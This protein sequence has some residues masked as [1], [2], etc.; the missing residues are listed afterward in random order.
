MKRIKKIAIILIAFCLCMIIFPLNSHADLTAEQRQKV[1]NFAK[2]FVIKGN[3]KDL[4]RYSQD[5]RWYGYRNQLS[6]HSSSNNLNSSF[7]NKLAFD[8]SSFAAFVYDQTCDAGLGALTTSTFDSSLEFRHVGTYNGNTN[9]LLVGDLL[10]KSYDHIVIYI[11]NG[12]IAHASEPNVQTQVKI[13]DL[14]SYYNGYTILRYKGSPE[15][16]KGF[17]SY[18]WPDGTTSQWTDEQIEDFE[19]VG[20][21]NGVFGS[22]DLIESGWIL[23]KLSELLDWF[24]GMTTYIVRMVFVGWTSIIE[25]MING[26]MELTSGEEASLTIE[27]LVNNKVPIFDVNFFNFE[28]AGGVKLEEGSVI[29]VIRENIAVWYYIIRSIAIV[30]LLITLLYLGIRMALAT[31]GE[32]KAK[33]KE[34]LVSW[35]VSFFIV[36][37]I[38]YIMILILNINSGLIDVINTSLARWRRVII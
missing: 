37:F 29:Y 25:M 2:A 5:N 32:Q 22:E 15:T 23:N 20:S 34:M 4:L 3:E 1:A 12:Q 35:L 16:V 11:G 27:K 26:V 17:E 33:Y 38:H 19:F 24:I 10:C 6:S 9:N 36:F 21:Q 31:V 7:T 14:S 8:C 18:V 30:G 28:T 13:N